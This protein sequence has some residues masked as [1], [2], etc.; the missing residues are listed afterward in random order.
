MLC[1]LYHLITM[2]MSCHIL[3]VWGIVWWI[4]HP[5]QAYLEACHCTGSGYDPQEEDWDC[6]ESAGTSACAFPHWLP[7]W[8]QTHHQTHLQHN[9]HQRWEQNNV[10]FLGRSSGSW[11]GARRMWHDVHRLVERKSCHWQFKSFELLPLCIFLRFESFYKE[12][13]TTDWVSRLLFNNQPG[14]L[15]LI[16]G[17]FDSQL[18]AAGDR[19]YCNADGA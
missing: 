17:C 3:Y 4:S 10:T 7:W 19:L 18:W 13:T 15:R 6:P 8:H 12:W 16:A 9:H 1:S 2:M 14:A 5:G 11:A